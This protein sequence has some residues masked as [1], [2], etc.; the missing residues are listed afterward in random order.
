[1]LPFIIFECYIYINGA[2]LVVL[3]ASLLE[4]GSSE[5]YIDSHND[6]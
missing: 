4:S 5:H 1:M 3:S 2:S 6:S